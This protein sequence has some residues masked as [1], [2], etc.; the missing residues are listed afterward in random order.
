MNFGKHPKKTRGVTSGITD[1]KCV[2]KSH[3]TRSNS[4]SDTL[5]YIINYPEDK[6]FVI[7]AADRKVYPI[8]A[9]SDEGFFTLENEISKDCFI[10]GIE[11]ISKMQM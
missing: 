1:L 9:Y 6:G 7:V 11:N 4:I 2:L 5:A 8:L 10:D 3:S